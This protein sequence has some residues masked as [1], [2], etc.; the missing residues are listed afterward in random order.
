V[1]T[2]GIGENSVTIRAR[3]ADNHV[4]NA[5][6]SVPASSPAGPFEPAGLRRGLGQYFL[7][8]LNFVWSAVGRLSGGW[9]DRDVASE[10]M[11]KVTITIIAL[12]CIFGRAHT[13]PRPSGNG[14]RT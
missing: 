9:R 13:G 10:A 5:S 3:I 8:L 4:T 6:C 11:R 12:V 2:A 1:F 7:V 14:P